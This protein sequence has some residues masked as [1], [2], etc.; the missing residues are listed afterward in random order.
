MNSFLEKANGIMDEIV[1]IRRDIHAHPELGH[2]EVRTS[3]LIREKLETYGV[4]EIQSLT[5]T[6]VVA[7]IKGKKGHGKC[8]ALRTDIDALPVEEET[9]LPFASETSGVMHACGHDIHTAMMLGN[10][11]LLCEM[12]DQFA[13]TVKLIF[14]HSEDTFPG[15]SK[16][17]IEQGVMNG[18]DAILGIH[19]FPTENDKCGVIGFREGPFTTSADEYL[20][21]ITGPGGHGSEPHKVP[22][23]IL[24][25]AEMIMMFQQVQARAIAP[26]DT[27][28]FMMNK[29]QG[30]KAPNIIS[31]KVTMVGNA[32]AYTAEARKTIEEYVYRIAEGV[33]KI[34]GCKIDVH[35]TLGYDACF[36]DPGLVDWIRPVLGEIIGEDRVEAFPDPMG[37]SE[38]FSFYS[39]LT[40]VP[41]LFMILQAGTMGEVAPLHNAHCSFNEQAMPY[42]MAAM[43]GSAIKFLEQ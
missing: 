22:D 37:F 30:G 38:D 7:V 28:I 2:K 31:D 43:T 1:A 24:A 14:Q 40:G 3:A 19:V 29:I 34:S 17:L 18:V 27:A 21:D 4:D 16:E 9:G 26:R 25:A 11:K 32:R 41:A 23:P 8:I 13:G 39:T 15:G 12:R 5:E 36:N 42:G 10:A 20:F 33:E 35:E 6:S